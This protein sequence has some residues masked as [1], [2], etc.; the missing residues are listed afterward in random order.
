[1]NRQPPGTHPPSSPAVGTKAM[2]AGPIILVTEA[3][4]LPM[5]KKPIA[6]PCW[7]FGNQAAFHAEPIVKLLPAMP[8]RNAA[9]SMVG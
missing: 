4:T 2:S 8:T 7:F 1:M 9:A 3:P 6:K 5:P